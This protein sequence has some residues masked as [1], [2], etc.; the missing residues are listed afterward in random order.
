MCRWTEGFVFVLVCCFVIGN[1]RALAKDDAD[2]LILEEEK[3]DEE[4]NQDAAAEAEPE[5]KSD[6]DDNN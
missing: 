3:D 5:A 2:R 4:E 6:N 1:K